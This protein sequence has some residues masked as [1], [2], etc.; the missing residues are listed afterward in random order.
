MVGYFRAVLI[1]GNFAALKM[2]KCV[3]CFQVVCGHCVHEEAG[4]EDKLK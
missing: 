3:Y 2:E 4:T 1:T